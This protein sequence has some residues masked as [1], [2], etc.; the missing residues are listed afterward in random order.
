MPYKIERNPGTHTYKVINTQTNFIHAAST[1]KA[2]AEAQIRLL[3]GIEHG[4]KPIKK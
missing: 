2:K 3:H 1:T 4:L